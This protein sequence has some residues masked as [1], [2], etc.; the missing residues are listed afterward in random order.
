MQERPNTNSRH[1]CNSIHK[2]SC[3]QTSKSICDKSR[4]TWRC[5]TTGL[6]NCTSRNTLHT[7]ADSKEHKGD[8][9]GLL[10]SIPVFPTWTIPSS[11]WLGPIKLK[12]NLTK[13]PS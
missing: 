11:T 3:A 10:R 9:K 5:M 1:S 6:G 7:K 12:K 4:K 8:T 2:Q 13:P